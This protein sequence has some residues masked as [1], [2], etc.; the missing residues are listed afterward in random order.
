MAPMRT[1]YHSWFC[2]YSRKARIVLAEKGLEVDLKIEKPWERRRE[3]LALNPSGTVPVLIEANGL[4]VADNHAITEYLEEA[5]PER[6][7]MGE[8]PQMRAEVR[9]LLWWFDAKFYREVT[10][11]VVTEKVM[12]RFLR[13]GEPDSEALRV[14]AHNIRI[15]LDY[16]AYLADRRDWLAGDRMTLADIAAAA[17][18]SAADYLGAVPWESNE[19]AKAWYMRIKS[20]P[21]MRPILK[22]F[23][24]GLRPPAHYADLDF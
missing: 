2:P 24:A 10:N 3:F 23:V 14:A 13:Q 9:R 20:R 22:D 19:R 21:S 17:H 4:V 11:Y 12:K 8:T 1:L 5:Y 7:L 15:H 18:L 16:I 6:N